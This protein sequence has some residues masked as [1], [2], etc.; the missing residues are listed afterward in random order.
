[1]SDVKCQMSNVS[2]LISIIIPVYNHEQALKQALASIAAQTYK[3]IE[4]IIV[5]DGSAI[6]VK[7]QVSS[8]KCL[9]LQQQNRGA[10]AARNRGLEEA[11]GECVIFWD[12][13]VI[14]RPDMLERMH[15]ALQQDSG[16]SY[17]YS[18]FRFGW[19]KMPARP[20]DS[21]ALRKNNYIHTTSLIRRSALPVKPWD[22]SLKRFQDWDLWLTLL[23]Q[24]KI[25][26]HI[27]EYLFRVFSHKRGMSHW[28]P[29]FAYQAPWRW[30]PGVGGWVR[31]YEA[32][33]AV[34]VKKHVF[35]W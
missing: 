12:A 15:L 25:G 2:S 24:K 3:D 6:P 9:I 5:D 19:K 27:P 33:R 17:A 4:V 28:L 13:D 31:E 10:P 1:M 16:A 26:V 29:S 11:K 14:A 34:V 20:F 22:E 30:L 8:V 7:C 21:E 18:D 32:A 23:E 35:E